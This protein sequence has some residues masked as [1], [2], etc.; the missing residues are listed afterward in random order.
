MAAEILTAPSCTISSFFSSF[1]HLWCQLCSCNQQSTHHHNLLS[2]W[3]RSSSP[4]NPAT[5]LLMSLQSV[6]SWH[7]PT[8]WIWPLTLSSPCNCHL[9]LH[10]HSQSLLCPSSAHL[11]RLLL[12]SLLQGRPPRRSCRSWRSHQQRL[13]G[14]CMRVIF[15]FLQLYLLSSVDS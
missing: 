10:F 11:H 14:W 7:C 5:D 13:E 2:G 1:R 8:S 9:L 6:L 15:D 4:G 12:R 3:I